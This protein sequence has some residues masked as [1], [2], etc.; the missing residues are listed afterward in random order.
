MQALERA[1]KIAGIG[2]R[3]TPHCLRHSFATHLFER[4]TDIRYIQMSRHK[5]NSQPLGDH[6]IPA[7]IDCRCDDS[8][9]RGLGRHDPGGAQAADRYAAHLG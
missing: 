8:Q 7:S 9:A 6:H 1:V 4:G 5:A 3:A 2:K